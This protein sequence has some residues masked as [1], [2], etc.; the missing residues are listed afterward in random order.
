MKNGIR[1]APDGQTAH[2]SVALSETLAA[3]LWV[4]DV[5]RN[6][7]SRI[8]IVNVG[9]D[10][11]GQPP[12]ASTSLVI[13]REPVWQQNQPIL[14]VAF[15]IAQSSARKMLVLEPQQ[16]SF[17]RW[18]GDRW[19]LDG[20]SPFPRNTAVERA[21]R[22]LLNYR[23]E[24]LSVVLEREICRSSATPGS[25]FKCEGV[26]QHQLLLADQRLP[27]LANKIGMP[28]SL[29]QMNL[30]GRSVLFL[31]LPDGSARMYEAGTEH[32]AA[33]TGWGSDI[34][35]VQSGCGAGWQLFATGKGDWTTTD[36]VQAYEIRDR[37][38]MPV[39][40]AIDF[41]GPILSLRTSDDSRGALA[42]VKNLGTHHYEVY[43]LSIACEK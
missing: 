12:R 22:G 31:T 17:F 28:L 38:A 20:A 35:A 13:R 1:L 3:Y 4:A 23:G 30:S 39:S 32:T 24:L 29:A 19:V 7:S 33:F 18:Q 16:I 40:A 2:I 26:A 15:P 10:V 11:R 42:V 8:F 21:P 41:P 27:L 34:A 36:T 25:E 5:H 6:D 43:N 14:D 9:R 37:Q